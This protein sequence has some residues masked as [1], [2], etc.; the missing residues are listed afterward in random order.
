MQKE[1][2]KG[3]SIELLSR[4]DVKTVDEKGK[5]DNVAVVLKP[6]K[7]QELLCALTS[8]K[9]GHLKS[10]VLVSGYCRSEFNLQYDPDAVHN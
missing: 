2:I 1:Q 3:M 8:M 5:P 10:V 7:Q 4:V 9:L 6:N